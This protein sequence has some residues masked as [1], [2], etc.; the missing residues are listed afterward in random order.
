MSE[1]YKIEA[2]VG[3]NN[4]LVFKPVNGKKT[5]EINPAYN[6]GFNERI[7]IHHSADFDSA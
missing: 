1:V 5:Y 4:F 3:K 6:L 2:T 7:L